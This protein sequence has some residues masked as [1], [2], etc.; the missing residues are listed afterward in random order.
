MG[1]VST[2]FRRYD[3]FPSFIRKRKR[4]AHCL[5][6]VIF[7]DAKLAAKKKKKYD[8]GRSEQAEEWK[9][10]IKAVPLV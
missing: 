4:S 6:L 8:N 1:I 7:A 9:E 2:F 5:P 10:M 3:N